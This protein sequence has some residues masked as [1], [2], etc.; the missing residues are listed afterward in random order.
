MG[1]LADF[2]R[3]FTGGNVDAGKKYKLED[4][5]GRSVMGY[6]EYD[7]ATGFNV[8][9]DFKPAGATGAKASA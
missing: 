1:R 4:T 7:V 2:I 3:C 6:A 9:K 5:V 8:I